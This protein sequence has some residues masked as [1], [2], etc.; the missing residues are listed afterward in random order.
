METAEVSEEIVKEVA[1]ALHKATTQGML[2]FTSSWTGIA[3]QFR[4]GNMRGT[5]LSATEVEAALTRLAQDP[6][7][8]PAEF[9]AAWTL[10][11]ADDGG[12]GLYGQGVRTFSLKKKN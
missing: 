9:Q 3:A 12:G 8:L 4:N 5:A 2:S 1:A 11:S 10:S 7:S 6:S